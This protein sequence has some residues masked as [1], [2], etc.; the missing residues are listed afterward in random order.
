MIEGY[1]EQKAGDD[2]DTRLIPMSAHRKT[3]NNKHKP[4]IYIV[5]VIKEMTL[6]NQ[7]VK[8]GRRRHEWTKLRGKFP[9]WTVLWCNQQEHFHAPASLGKL[10]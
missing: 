7:V 9:G 6:W 2:V 4:T 10:G 8:D 1:W 3:T 5:R